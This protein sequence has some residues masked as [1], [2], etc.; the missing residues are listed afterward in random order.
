M[1]ANHSPKS[2]SSAAEIPRSAVGDYL[3]TVSPGTTFPQTGSNPEIGVKVVPLYCE[4]QMQL[5]MLASVPRSAMAKLRVR[6]PHRPSPSKP[7]R[8][9]MV[10]MSCAWVD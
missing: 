2:A 8:A 6:P 10:L 4:N 3:G 9:S 1:A 5:S 7:F